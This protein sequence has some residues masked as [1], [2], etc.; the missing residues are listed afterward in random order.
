MPIPLPSF[1]IVVASVLFVLLSASW[2]QAAPVV[3]FS[4]D[5]ESG[6]PA[7][8]SAPGCELDGVQG[9]AGLG[10]PG[11]QFGGVFL[12]YTSVP[13]HPTTLTVRNLP[14]HDHLSLK[15]LLAVIDSWDGTELMQVFVD[16]SLRFNNWFQLA[17]GDTTS[18]HPAPPGA[19]L[20]MGTNL[21]FSGC[22]Y[23]NRDRAYDLGVEPA[24]LEIPHVADSVVVTWAISAVS[25]PAADQWQG[26]DDESWAIDAVSVEVSSQTSGVPAGPGADGLSVC[27]M[28]NPMVGGA[29]RLRLTLAAA[30]RARVEL[31]DLSG[32]R[33]AV[34][35]VDATAPGERVVDLAARGR[36]VPGLYFARV[37]QGSHERTARVSVTH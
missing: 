1:R 22:C 34:R 19:I 5:F 10:P 11:R 7:E 24:F 2:C 14:P 16:D 25:G 21:G 29:P 30:G 23:Y 28:P 12:R 36:L 15:F 18:Y 35:V 26:G 8:F 31:L 13:I 37:T 32:R 3:V 6:I 4:T 27:A 17:T 9:Y 20:S 33:V